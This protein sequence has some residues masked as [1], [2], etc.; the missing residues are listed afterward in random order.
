MAI[1]EHSVVAHETN[2][3]FGFNF[4]WWDRIFGTYHDQP[5]A[6]HEDMMIG[7][8]QYHDTK[9]AHLHWMLIL[10]FVGKLG[11]HTI[12]RCPNRPT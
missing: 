11:S 10:P 1:W 8:A 4:P 3:N 6:G 2:S 12:N 5:A 9:I 7:F